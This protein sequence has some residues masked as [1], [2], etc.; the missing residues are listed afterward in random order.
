M[1]LNTWVF[2]KKQQYLY[3]NKSPPPKKKSNK[4]KSSLSEEAKGGLLAI[5]IAILTDGDTS[6][7]DRRKKWAVGLISELGDSA[8]NVWSPFVGRRGGL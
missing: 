7:D 3:A 1:N 8:T 6:T 2:L 4:V 5:C